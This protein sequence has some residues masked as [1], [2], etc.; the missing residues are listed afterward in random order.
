[1]SHLRYFCLFANSGVQHILCCVLSFIFLRLVYPM[2]S[3]FLEFPFF[4]NCPFGILYHVYVQRRVELKF[5]QWTKKD[6]KL[7]TLVNQLYTLK[8][9]L[10]KDLLQ[11]KF[12]GLNIDR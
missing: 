11:K 3:A 5:L 12:H 9:D 10:Y 4:F 8:G 1:M 6:L 2:L 7:Q